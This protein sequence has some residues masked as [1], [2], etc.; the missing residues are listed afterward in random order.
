MF[1]KMNFITSKSLQVLHFLLS[2]PMGQFYE[3][4]ISRQTNVSIGAVNQ[5]LR[6]FH[7]M[8]LVEVQ[9]R[10]KINLYRANLKNPVSRQFK[11]LFNMFT[12][13]E[14]ITEISQVS[15]RVVLFGSCA[16]GTDTKESDVDLFILTSEPS[17]IQRDIARYEE[18]MTR[19]ISPIIVDSNE[20]ARM[21]VNDKP[22]YERILR[23]IV[24]WEKE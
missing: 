4:E 10:G 24:L 11:V 16:D 19:R 8:G 1:K 7:K 6:N 5:F 20:F 23:G 9:K 3:R 22:L 17:T 13:N 18:G 12:L 14:L 2:D 21:R 15:D